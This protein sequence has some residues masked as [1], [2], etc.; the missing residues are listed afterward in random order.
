M[1]PGGSDRS[2]GGLMPACVHPD[3]QADPVP[4]T[5]TCFIH[6]PT[7][8]VASRV[9]AAGAKAMLL[10]DPAPV[11]S[12]ERASKR[13]TAKLIRARG[14]TLQATED[15]PEGVSQADV[16]AYLDEIALKVA[17]ELEDEDG[18]RKVGDSGH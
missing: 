18:H 1:S 5:D 3:C 17:E 9:A 10:D 12:W 13:M 6:S 4:G 8:P 16:Q 7:Y 2:I 15:L 14:I 11:E